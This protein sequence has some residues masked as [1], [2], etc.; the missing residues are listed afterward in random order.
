M[1]DREWIVEKMFLF[2]IAIHHLD[3]DIYLPIEL[4][5]VIACLGLKHN[6]IISLPL[7]LPASSNETEMLLEAAFATAA[8][9]WTLN[10]PIPLAS[11][12]R[13]IQSHIPERRSLRS[14]R[15]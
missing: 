1:L 13:K 11:F 15:H 8:Q 5:L 7:I 4:V 2:F 6:K 3:S 14:H 9:R 10:L 12:I